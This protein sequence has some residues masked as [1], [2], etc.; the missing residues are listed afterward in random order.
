MQCSAQ[1]DRSLSRRRAKKRRGDRT[2]RRRWL[3]LESLE[4]RRLLAVNLAPENSVPEAEQTTQV[5]MPLAFTDF[6]GNPISV[7]DPDAAD[8]EVQ[9]TLDAT[10]GLVSLIDV[11][12]NDGLTYSEGDGTLDETMTF[13]G[14][15]SDV[16]VIAYEL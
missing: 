14:T 10:H 9:I 4:E 3:F 2:G 11:N 12:P 13:S 7:S 5:D 16:I 1:T 6:R 15:L 8:E